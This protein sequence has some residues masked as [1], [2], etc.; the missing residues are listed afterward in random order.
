MIKKT[1]TGN[2]YLITKNKFHVRD[3]TNGVEPIDL[4]SFYKESDY[5]LIIENEIK[6]YSMNIMQ[7]EEE[8][9]EASK[10]VIVSDG[11]LF[12][13]KQSLLADLPKDVKII[14]V[15]RTLAKWK[16]S[17]KI[18]FYLVN[19]PYKEAMSY[20]PLK[21]NY[22]PCI[23]S[24]RTY[25]GFVAKYSKHGTTYMYSPT[26]GIKFSGVYRKNLIRVDDY[27][28]PICAAISLCH[29]IGI[30]KLLLFCCDEIITEQK[31]GAELVG[32]NLW[33]YPQNI[34]ASEL[35]DANLYWF[36]NREFIEV[37]VAKYPK[38][39]E[40]ENVSYIDEQNGFISFFS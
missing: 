40:Y 7:I 34:Q 5:D 39:L 38:G 29:R 9:I 3:F 35:I 2:R 20:L 21:N 12:D 4:N 36:K 32:E 30:S 15:N 13:E 8:L 17:R 25:H 11:Y 10:C 16:I 24:S 18:D 31:D 37:E 19:N 26:P 33:M 14:A 27:R 28:N 1:S 23:T 22:P 6:N